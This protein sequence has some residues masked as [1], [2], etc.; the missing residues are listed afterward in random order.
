VVHASSA[1]A[2]GSA[3]VAGMVSAFADELGAGEGALVAE[4]E[5]PGL[6]EPDAASSAAGRWLMRTATTT[7]ITTAT[8]PTASTM[9]QPGRRDRSP[10]ESCRDCGS[11]IRFLR[12]FRQTLNDCR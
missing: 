3:L 11:T 12:W 4:A 9:G 7:P 1:A 2:V 5:A 8:S 6:A 10:K